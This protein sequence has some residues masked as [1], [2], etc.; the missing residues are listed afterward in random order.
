MRVA[1]AAQDSGGMIVVN[2]VG[3]SESTGAF[4]ASVSNGPDPEDRK[5]VETAQREP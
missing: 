1:G 5:A 4:D 3:K 2:P